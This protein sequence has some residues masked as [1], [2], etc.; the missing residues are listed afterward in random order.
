MNFLTNNT[1][2]QIDSLII[3][4]VKIYLLDV[5]NYEGNYYIESDRWYSMPK[6]ESKNP[7]LQLK[8]TETQLQRLLEDLRINLSVESY[9][10]FVNPEFHLYQAP[11]DEPII[12]PTQLNRFCNKLNL[13]TSKMK[14]NHSNLAEKLLSIHLS[15]SPYKRI[16]DYNYDE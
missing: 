3:S 12:F 1:N 9:V 7:L 2:I 15:E 11:I 8:R 16:P 14:V 6:S 13:N 5:K 4:P 10:V